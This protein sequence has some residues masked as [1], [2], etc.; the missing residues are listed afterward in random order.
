MNIAFTLGTLPHRLTIFAIINAIEED[1]RTEILESLEPQAAAKTILGDALH[2]KTV[3]RFQAD[4]PG[5][6][7][8]PTLYDIVFYL[9]FADAY[10]VLNRNKNLLPSQTRSLIARCTPRLQKLAPIRNRVDHARPLLFDDL[11][12]AMDSAGDF[13]KLSSNFWHNTTRLLMRLETEPTFVLGLEIPIRT[14]DS[15]TIPHNLPTPEF[16]ETGFIGREEIHKQLIAACIGPYPVITIVG[17]GGVGK[18]ALAQKVAYDILDLSPS[19]FDAIV[20][21]TSKTTQLTAQEIVEIDGAI[22]NSLGMVRS[23][24]SFVQDS[25]DT[26]PTNSVLE[27]LDNFNILLVLDNI[28][29][30]LDENL[31]SFLSQLP[32]GSKVLITSRIGVG[33][34]EFPIRISPLSD[35]E[36][37]QFLRALLSRR[38][39][40]ELAAMDNKRLT[41]YCARMQNNPGF[42]KWFVSAVQAG[43]RPE[44]ILENPS[45]F[46]EYCMSNVYQYLSETSRFVISAMQAIATAHNQAQLSFL[47]DGMEVALLQRSL[48]ELLTTNMVVMKSIARGVSYETKYELSEMAMGY[49]RIHHA[50]PSDAFKAFLKRRGK[51]KGWE[52]EIRAGTSRNPY[53]IESIFLRSTADVLTAKALKDSLRLAKQEKPDLALKL[54]QEAKTLAP[55]Y[56]ECHR[57]EAFIKAELNDVYGAESAYLAAIEV[58]PDSAPLRFWYG[59]FRVRRLDDVQGALEQ[60]VKGLE[61]SPESVQLKQEVARLSMYQG[62]FRDCNERLRELETVEELE[63]WDRR[64]IADIRLQYFARLADSQC[65]EHDSW[66]ALISLE[67]MVNHYYDLD[68]VHRDNYMK[69]TLFKVGRVIRRCFQPIQGDEGKARAKEV[70]VRVLSAVGR[71]ASIEHLDASDG[72]GGVEL[73][74]GRII[75]FHRGGWF[76]NAELRSAKV[77]D[78]IMCMVD[79]VDDKE[80]AFQIKS[81]EGA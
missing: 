44:E 33:A 14:F 15:D 77:G 24:A 22:Q 5:I 68:E 46:L 41:R 9:D 67:N 71:K 65:M 66:G 50:V 29:T 23:I 78:L 10:E 51:L 19:P 52:Q 20:W 7:A 60:C 74:D 36:S 16:D 81:W 73:I 18:T 21:S 54:V 38:G 64:K 53:N 34:Y 42:I 2:A 55:D 4:T 28:E 56:F 63:P 47:C 80:M 31:R 76:D 79:L 43:R 30:V 57:V 39:L 3:Q 27:Y 12:T 59:Q 17:E 25:A 72:S 45:L 8:N 70:L 61:L 48:Q 32:S 35:S 13:S 11:L 6:S 62:H 37:I 58:N 69:K 1:L 26:D 49:L 40:R 75:P